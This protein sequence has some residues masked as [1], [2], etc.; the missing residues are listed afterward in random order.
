MVGPIKLLIELLYLI[1]LYNIIKL[2]IQHIKMT[3]VYEAEEG[4]AP[5]SSNTRNIKNIV[6]NNHSH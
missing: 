4:G 1:K 6:G 5:N 2:K 3:M